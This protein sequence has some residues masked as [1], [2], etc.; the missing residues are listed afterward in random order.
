MDLLKK[1]NPDMLIWSGFCGMFFCVPL[2]NS[3]VE[4]CGA[5]VLAVWILS[6]KF[7]TDMQ[8]WLHSVIALPVIA[9]II[10][11]WVGLAYTPVPS[12][13]L[14]V[15]SKGY[16]WLYSMAMTTV[17]RTQKSRDCIIRMFLA[18]LALDSLVSILQIVGIFSLRYGTPSGLLGISSPWITYSLLLTVGIFIA[19]FYFQKADKRNE[20]L[21]SLFL[22][23]LYFVTI[24]FVGGRSG[25]VAFIFLSPLLAY[26]IIGRRHMLMI[27]VLSLLAISILFTFPTVQSRFAQ[28]RKDVALY[29]QGN[30]NT[31]IGLRFH[32]WG[33]AL[34]EI[35]RNPLLGVGT[36]G[37]KKSWEMNK[38]DRSL[39]FFDH[40][41]NSFLYMLVS[42]GIAGLIAF[43]WL[44]F[45]ML[46]KGWSGR[47]T[48]SGF[49]LL[50][51][52][53]V[54][55]LG[56]FTD[57]QLLP[58]PTAIALTLFAGIAGA[59]DG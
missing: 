19:S 22:M 44:L 1:I 36:A 53:L 29:Q 47:N 27:A 49:A 17:L 42:F 48:P 21:L 15:A 56:S 38:N 7:L 51:F 43:C 13:G 57:T 32:M 23:L 14:N 41:H 55:T 35:K 52:T 28:I 54:F 18:G 39:P 46:Q 25:Y 9:M 20:R 30:I 5:L 11:P 10:L 4:I 40:P 34:S 26:N 58:F 6:G 24:G 37:F 45:V 2:A 59:I 31:S 12:D 3:P 16:Y 50:A 8:L 33:I